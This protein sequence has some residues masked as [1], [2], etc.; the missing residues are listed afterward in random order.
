MP[1]Q[2]KPGGMGLPGGGGTPSAFADSMAAAIESELNLL[3]QAEGLP[4]LALDNSTET[5][6]RRRL[7]VAIARGVV[8]HLNERREAIDVV[9]SDG[10]T[11]SPT[12]DILWS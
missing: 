10:V 11:S 12:F 7:F 6:D 8:R 3:L 5:R 4:K 9:D 1:T 2:I